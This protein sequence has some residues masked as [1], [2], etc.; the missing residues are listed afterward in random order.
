LKR[1]PPFGDPALDGGF[2][3]LRGSADRLLGTPAGGAQQPPAVI[4]MVADMKFVPNDRRD[5]LGGPYFPEEVE[6][7]GTPGEQPEKLGE[8]LSAELRRGA[9]WR[10]AV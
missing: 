3:A 1:W 6:G 5:A 4:G 8:L 10:L 7:L 9:G 2:I